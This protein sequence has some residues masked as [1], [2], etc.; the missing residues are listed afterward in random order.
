MNISSTFKGVLLALVSVIAVSNVYIFSK[1]ALMEVSLPQFGVYWFSFGLLWIFIYGCT[2]RTFRSVTLFAKD[3]TRILL[4]L[5]AI[6]IASSYFFFKA[7]YTISNPAITSFIGN[8]SPVFVISLSFLFLKERFNRMEFFGMLLALLGAFI[9]SY[10]GNAAFKD[11]FMEG[12]QYVIYAS[13]F[14]AVSAVI[15]KK[16]IKHIDPIVITTNRSLFL[17]TFSILAL[18]YTGESLVIGIKPLTNI[19]IGATLGPFLTVIS[20]YLALQYI[21]L[22]QRAIITSTKGLFVLLGAYL[23]F[24]QFPEHIALIGGLVTIIGLVLIAFGKKSKVLKHG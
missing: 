22:S 6:E 13:A 15:I 8:I 12:A 16:N 18:W 7:I 4:L 23:Y 10:K 14:S 11:M 20:S 3:H 24:G 9:I 1:A 17:L 5:G 21:P 19:A 2:Q